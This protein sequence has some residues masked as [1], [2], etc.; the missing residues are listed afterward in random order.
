MF[1]ASQHA[2]MRPFLDEVSRRAV[3][4]TRTANAQ[5][6]L[7]DLFNGHNGTIHPGPRQSRE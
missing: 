4:D 6:L 1:T 2:E 7:R 3:E 5:R